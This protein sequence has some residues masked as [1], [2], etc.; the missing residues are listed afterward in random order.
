MNAETLYTW[1][2]IITGSAF[3]VALAREAWRL[4]RGK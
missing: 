4:K 3:S 1:F 2:V